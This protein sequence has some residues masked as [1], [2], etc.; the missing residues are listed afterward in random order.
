MRLLSSVCASA[1]M[2]AMS[3]AVM[4]SVVSS[5]YVYTVELGTV[6]LMSLM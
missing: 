2:L 5:A 6:C 3:F 1:C 4:M